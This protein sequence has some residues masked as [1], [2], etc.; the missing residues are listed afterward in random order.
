M[1]QLVIKGG[2]VMDGTGK[3]AFRADIGIHDGQVAAVGS[4]DGAG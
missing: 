4:A 1:F 3:P 2:T